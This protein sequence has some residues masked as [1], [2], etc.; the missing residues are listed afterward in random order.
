MLTNVTQPNMMARRKSP[1]A[2]RRK[3]LLKKVG[4]LIGVRPVV[5]QLRVQNEPFDIVVQVIYEVNTKIHDVIQEGPTLLTEKA[6]KHSIMIQPDLV[7]FKNATSF[8]AEGIFDEFPA[9][10]TLRQ[11][12]Q[13][14]L[15]FELRSQPSPEVSVIELQSRMHAL[16][17][18]AQVDQKN[19]DLLLIG[20][21]A[22]VIDRLC[23]IVVVGWDIA[24]KRH[25]TYNQSIEKIGSLQPQQDHDCDASERRYRMVV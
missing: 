14:I 1:H 17:S 15:R 9:G 20:E 2:N 18:V 6:T 19:K 8:Q 13:L 3:T 23:D 4:E 21:I 22:Y 5:F 11:H 10:Q 24:Q 16:Q 12:E 7:L 25:V